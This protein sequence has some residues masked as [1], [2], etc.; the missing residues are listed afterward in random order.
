ACERHEVLPADEAAETAEAGVDGLE[1]VAVAES[2]DH[3]LVI[4]RHELAMANRYF[5]VRSKEEQRVVQ[6][7]PVQ[8]VDADGE[9]EPVLLRDRTHAVG[10]RARHLDRRAHETRLQLL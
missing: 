9:H 6:R 7:A 4:R 5:T 2:P 10:L 1:A 3:P 8:L